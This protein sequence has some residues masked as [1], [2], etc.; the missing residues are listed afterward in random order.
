MIRPD[1][2]LPPREQDPVV[3]LALT[4]LGEARNQPYQGKCAVAQVVKN[5]MDLKGKSVADT[6]LAPWQFSCW[7]PGDPNKVFLLEVI[8]KQAG[9]LREGDWEEALQAAEGALSDPREP[10]PTSGA[11]HYTTVEIWASD[12]ARRKKQRWHSLQCIGEGITKELAR[13]GSH[14]FGLTKW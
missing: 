9:N 13:I 10:D 12:D 6:V 14:V 5:R 7:N 11:T 2:A 3:L 1:P 8:A 4:V